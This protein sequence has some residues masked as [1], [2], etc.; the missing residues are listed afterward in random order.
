MC[1][2]IMLKLW[3]NSML[4]LIESKVLVLIAILHNLQSL[5]TINV[6]DKVV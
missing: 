6:N 2:T 4:I 3:T 5:L 1:T